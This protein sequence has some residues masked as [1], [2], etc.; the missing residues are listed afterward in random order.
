M[1]KMDKK[2]L[3]PWA[4]SALVTLV[5]LLLVVLFAT[6]SLALSEAARG[7]LGVTITIALIVF[8]YTSCKYA[9]VLKGQRK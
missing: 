9:G 7:V 3:I 5:C 2:T 8:A 4:I 6:G 1:K